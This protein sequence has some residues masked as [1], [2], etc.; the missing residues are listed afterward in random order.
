MDS[1]IQEHTYTSDDRNLFAVRID[2]SNICC[3]MFDKERNMYLVKCANGKVEFYKHVN[4]F[5]TLPK[6]DIR[7]MSKAMFFNLSKDPQADAFA[8]FILD[9]CEKDF[10]AMHTAKDDGY[11]SCRFGNGEAGRTLLETA[12]PSM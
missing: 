1:D 4:D 3:W 7:S 5:C 12:E 2:R 6:V 8:R 11:I 9:Q 10:P